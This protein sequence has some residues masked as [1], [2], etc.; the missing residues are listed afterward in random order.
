MREEQRVP[1]QAKRQRAV[2]G[3]LV[4]VV[5][6]LVFFGARGAG[7]GLLVSLLCE[8]AAACLVSA[9]IG[10]VLGLRLRRARRRGGTAAS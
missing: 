1:R 6:V 2:Q 8:V 5:A 9:L 7:L 10:L 4:Q 3:A